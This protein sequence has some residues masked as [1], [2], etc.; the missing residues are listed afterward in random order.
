MK[1][2]TVLLVLV[3]AL[4]YF[5]DAY[6]LILFVVLR[7]SSLEELGLIGQQNTD[8]GLILFNIQMVGMLIGGVLFGI[9][10]DKK[11]RLSVLFGSI[12]LYSLANI[13]NGFVNDVWTYGVFRFLA[14]IGLAGELGVGVTIVAE[15]MPK[16]IRG[17][18]TSILA[19]VGA[20]GAV[21][22]ALVGDAFYWRYA[23]YLGGGMGLLLLLLRFGIFE[24]EMFKKAKGQTA[25]RGDF[26]SLFTK[27]DRFKRY[28]A[29]MLI[30]FPIFFMVTILMQMAP[31]VAKALGI[32]GKVTAGQA[33]MYVYGGLA[34]G[35]ILSGFV[36]QQLQS[37]RKTI[38][39]FQGIC[40]VMCFV[41]LNLWGATNTAVFVT[42]AIMGAASGYWI[43]LITMSAEQFGTNLRATVATT[44]PNFARGAAV[45]ITIIHQAITKWLD[46]DLIK[47]AIIVGIITFGAAFWANS[48]LK[49]SFTK[50]LDYVE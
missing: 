7:K 45:P 3:A 27:K 2:S 26:I 18:G 50:D 17:Y 19:M 4:G 14:G 49:E 22:A 30:G 40:M 16:E 21:V 41:Y 43:V 1:K 47:A 23:Y 35:D 10:G 31:E 32:Q 6:D 12:V 20:S 48:T 13:A 29:C 15:S 5:V 34:F 36:S 38:F 11:G 39:I 37:R 33:V 24:S 28:L 46:G 8:I 25:E 42:C 44:I 9:L